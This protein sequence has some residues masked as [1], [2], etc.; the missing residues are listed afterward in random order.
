M[1][2]VAAFIILCL[3]AVFVGILS[4]FKRDVGTKFFKVFRKA[5]GCVWKKVRLQKCDTNFKEDI[6][7]SMLKKVVLK[8]P[9]L[10][11]PISIA[12]EVGAVLVVLVTVWSLVEAGKAGLSLFAL[13]TC[14][15]RVPS[16]CLIGD[17]DFCPTVV[18]DMNWFQEWGEIFRAIPDRFRSFDE[19]VLL[20]ELESPIFLSQG[21]G[22]PV[23][24]VVSDVGCEL[25]L[26]SYRN[27]LSEGAF[28]R[29][30]VV[31]I[32]Y[33][34]AGE[35]YEFRYANSDLISR[36][37]L[38]NKSLAPVILHRLFAEY[39]EGEPWALVFKRIEEIE[40]KAILRSWVD[41]WIGNAWI[42]AEEA[43][44]AEIR[45]EY[46]DLMTWTEKRLRITGVPTNIHDGRRRT[47]MFEG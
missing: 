6:K 2:C 42:I 13:G 22:R 26:Q 18:E 10:V 32:P 34:T 37:M 24:I 1:V 46:R 31:F 7:N 43:D 21:E 28:E 35:T 41:E 33:S 39:H 19:E 38:A 12:I 5:W 20:A 8:K 47:G 36:Y 45:Q 17:A 30:T 15:P 11:K 3:I 9:K 16:A 40:A 25:C 44:S 4:I 14:T 27:M 29:Y 23:F